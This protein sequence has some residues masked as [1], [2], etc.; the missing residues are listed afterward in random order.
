MGANDGIQIAIA[1][2]RAAHSFLAITIKNEDCK[3]GREFLPLHWR[4]R[5]VGGVGKRKEV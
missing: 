1:Y 3:R 5:H 2:F 4:E